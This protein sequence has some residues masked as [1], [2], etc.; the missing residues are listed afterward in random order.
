MNWLRQNIPLFFSP[1]FWG[2]TFAGLFKLAALHNWLPEADLDI[3]A[4][5]LVGITGVNV[6][7]KAAKKSAGQ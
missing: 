4:A 7:W 6:I 2:L 3:V 1:T 5:W